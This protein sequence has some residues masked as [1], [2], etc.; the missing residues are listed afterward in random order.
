MKKDKKNVVYKKLTVEI[1]LKTF[2]QMDLYCK[3]D[4]YPG[5]KGLYYCD[6]IKSAIEFYIDNHRD[7]LSSEK[8]WQISA[9]EIRE[10]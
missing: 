8:I 3:S 5:K 1:P 7:L 9:L 4:F 2:L 10:I 6:F